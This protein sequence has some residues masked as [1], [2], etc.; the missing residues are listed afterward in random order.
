[1]AGAAGLLH[2]RTPH[3]SRETPNEQQTHHHPGPRFLGGAA[4]WSR[5]ILELSRLGHAGLHAVELPLTSLADDAERLRK[6]I[7]SL[8]RCCWPAI[9]TAAP[10]SPEAGNQPNVTGLCIAAFA[11]D[12]GEARAA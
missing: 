9:P 3:P 4:H 1:M 5:V 7:A 12:A 11:P 10:S 2:D 6:M 8:A